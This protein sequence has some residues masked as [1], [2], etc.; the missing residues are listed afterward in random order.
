[1]KPTNAAV[2]ITPDT[3]VAT[4][5]KDFPELED[6]LLRL[7]PDFAKLR[8]PIL[9]RTVARVTSLRQAAKIAGLPLAEMIN[10]LRRA[11]GQSE[12]DV[13]E[14]GSVADAPKPDWVDSLEVW[15]TYDARSLL[16]SG[17]N[18][19]GEVIAEAKALPAGQQ[20]LLQ[21]SFLPAPLI[22]ILTKKGLTVWS[23]PEVDGLVVTHITQAAGGK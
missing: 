6:E 12:A 3:K 7:S 21:T 8:N 1:M 4:F 10:T 23:A 2:Q 5:L 9:R 19:M 20:L 17:G 18:P 14:D 16:E 11:A 13:V 22:D 15:K